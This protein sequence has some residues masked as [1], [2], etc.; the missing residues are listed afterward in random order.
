MSGF[1]F[2]WDKQK[3]EIN[4]DKHGVSFEDAMTVFDD[5]NAITIYDEHNSNDEDRFNIIGF[6]EDSNVLKVCHCYRNGD[7]VIRIISARI[8]KKKEADLYWR[9][10]R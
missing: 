7:Q 10:L 8:A 4:E 3:A 1:R 5:K 9:R 6:S 2:E